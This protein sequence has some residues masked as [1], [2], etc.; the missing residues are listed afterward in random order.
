MLWRAVLLGSFVA[1]TARA[2]SL[3]PNVPIRQLNHRVFTSAEGA[4]SNV[5]SLVQTSDGTLWIGGGTGLTRFDGAH[6]VAYPSPPEEPLPSTNISA[7]TAGPNGGLWLGFRIGGA[8]FLKAGRLKSFTE[9][10]GFPAGTV[11][12]FVV[13]RT[14]GVWA[15]ARGGVA[16][17]DGKHWEKVALD[18]DPEC[19]GVLV[20][21]QGT[22]WVATRNALLARRAGET[23]FREVGS[24]KFD[25]NSSLTVLAERPDGR[26]W[27]AGHELVRID[28]PATLEGSV[29]VN[30][31]GYAGMVL[32]AMAFDEGGNLW[33]TRATHSREVLRIPAQ[34]LARDGDRITV[35][36]EVYTG[37]DGLS[38][39]VGP[40]LHDREGNVWLGT[41]QGLDR[42]SHTNVLH[43]PQKCGSPALAAGEG[44]AL[45]IACRNVSGV[46]SKLSDGTIVNQPRESDFPTV[47]ADRPGSVWF[48]GRTALEHLENGR[49]E[50]IPLPPRLQGTEVQALASD[51]GGG[52][53]VSVVRRGVFRYAAGQWSDYG[54]VDALPRGPA[55][56]EVADKDGTLWFG[57]PG[58][59]IA[60][61]RG[62]SVQ[63]FGAT[64]GLAVGNV[65]SILASG[66]DVW[67]GG[68]LGLAHLDH[69][70]FMSVHRASG[71]ALQG[72]SGIVRARSGDFWLNGIDGISRIPRE[73]IARVNSDSA[74]PVRSDNYNYLDGVL[75]SATQIRPQPSAIETS[76]GL[77]WFSMTGG[78]VSIDATRL[79]RNSLPPPVTIWSV[80]AG[81]RRYAN[82]LQ[83]VELPINATRV[84]IDYSAGSL[85]VPERV[86]F[87]YKLEGSDSDWQ[88]VGPR[89]EAQY[90]NL[91]PG[92][93]TFR[94]IASNNDGI[95]N[96]E[97]AQVVFTIAPAFYQTSWFYL[98]CGIACLAL[99]GTLYRV[100]VRQVAS[101]VR[102]R[103][104]ARL[105]ER[106]RIARELHDT[107][108][109][110]M[111][112]LIWR[113][114]A[115]TDRIPTDQ[116]ARQLM[117]Q[118]LDRA[119][120]LLEES[121]EKVKDL[122]PDTSDATDLAQALA[123]E[124]EQFAQVHSAKFRVSAE[125]TP[126]G[127]H[128]IVREEGLLVGREALSNAFRHSGATNIEVEVTYDGARLHIRVRDDGSG[129]DASVLEANGK[130]GHFGLMGMR[131][132]A[133]K[134]GG[135]LQIW[136]KPGAGTEIDLSVP[137]HVAYR[138]SKTTSDRT[139]AHISTSP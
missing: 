13:D 7:L 112:G 106:E 73:E 58:S 86:Q 98:L 95:W 99:L 85:T 59:R 23:R 24:M 84:Q 35:T 68:E 10:D 78:A 55:I 11:S 5:Y 1:I 52:L 92:R 38:G 109:Q 77:V 36:P 19:L 57:Y 139:R 105:A 119:D 130:P 102:G 16:H 81:S 107:L 108:L 53:W 3:Y 50:T 132:R 62:K 30:I 135:A 28:R 56:V 32:D 121:R 17:F 48:G 76:D 63:L 127:L 89:R 15:A 134:M 22:L 104:E 21:R 12:N 27:A 31:T 124:G 18:G 33:A 111:Q 14:G 75:G 88:D 40:I 131:E 91:G 87:R 51:S 115:A 47:Y 133:K 96:T 26:I 125:G 129:I 83:D 29:V 49:S 122:R 44:G 123:A 103:L 34:E 20:D 94:V 138:Q 80:A 117:E 72:I 74:Y 114:Q 46:M 93:Y 8:S 61:L 116:P 64:Q 2:E 9:T 45:W 65:L 39:E 97:G 100:R 41:V 101:Q 37:T 6:F 128:P 69:G 70:H 4:P 136:S 90:T 71:T 110:G 25:F 67:V 120:K 42:L 54:D 82:L 79:V 137:A 118:S 43:G 113:F 60:R 66:D 126:R